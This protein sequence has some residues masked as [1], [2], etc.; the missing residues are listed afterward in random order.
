MTYDIY[1]QKENE[2]GSKY[3]KQV[4]EP[5]TKYNGKTESSILGK[6]EKGRK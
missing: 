4:T 5:V 6:I 1:V 2:D 3:W